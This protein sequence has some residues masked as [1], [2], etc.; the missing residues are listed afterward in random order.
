MN[1][2]WNGRD[3]LSRSRVTEI[4]PVCALALLLAAP[5]ARAQAPGSEQLLSVASGHSVVVTSPG[6]LDRVSIA[7]PQVADAVVVSS[8]EVVVNGKTPGSTSLLLW[9]R[10]GT[11]HT[12]SVRVTADAASLQQELGRLFPDQD[13]KASA[14]GNTIILSGTVRDERVH[15][16]AL[17]LAHSLGENVQVVDNVSIPDRGQV[18]LH[19]RFAEVSRNA[20]KDFGSEL[21]TYEGKNVDAASASGSSLRPSND[22]NFRVQ[23]T[24][25]AVNLFL[26]HNPSGVSAFIH[27]LQTKGL[28]RSLAEPDLMVVPGDTASFLA[29]GEFPYPVLQGGG[30]NNSVTIQ[31][32]EF[33]IRLNFTPE[34]ENSGAIRLHVAPEV[35]QLD[36]ANGLQVSGFNIPALTS[37]KAQ[38]VIELMPG[39]TFAIAG[40]LDNSI[41]KN[42]SKVPLLG[43]IPILGAL[44][45]SEDIRQN[46]SELLVLVTPH[47][48][49]P[50]Q[51][52]PPPPL[53]TGEP[54]KWPWDKSMRSPANDPV[55]RDPGG[56]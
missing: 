26:F 27:A 30:N 11:R 49:Q 45:R 37:R 14:F 15:S 33:G 22:P 6:V 51:A 25:D 55:S 17:A 34:L 46:R 43:D 36:F 28:F 31:F 35:S 50:S 7:D 56:R 13:L 44:F 18:L 12:Y 32:K 48:I 4:L 1:N 23:T 42:V 29:G 5:A 2:S 40:L 53:P 38:T 39:Q 10:D 3:G 16:K 41:T 47:L 20:I 54:E 24:S 8:V 52:Q 21:L 19:V 9:Q